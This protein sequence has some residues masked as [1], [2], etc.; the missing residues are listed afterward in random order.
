MY[1]VTMVNKMKEETDQYLELLKKILTGSIYDESSWAMIHSGTPGFAVPP[2][3]RPVIVPLRDALVKF[4]KR[5]NLLLVKQRPFSQHERNEGSGW[6]L[7][8]YTMVGH[9]RLDNVQF[10]VGEVLKNNIPG[11]FIETGVWRGGT[12]IFFRALLK[13]HNVADRNVWLAD[14]FEGL[15][16]PK[17]GDDGWDMSQNDYLKVSMEKVKSNFERFGLLD[18]QVKFIPGWF[19]ESLPKAPVQKLAI[20]RLDGDL[21]SSTMDALTNLYHKVSK[22]GFVIVDDYFSWPACQ[23]AMTEFIASNSIQCKIEKID[24]SA[25]YWK[26]I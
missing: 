1:T 19:S 4:L 17:S 6:P 13:A 3:L 14:S 20:L 21:Y 5:R 18:D 15:P 9:R 12:A 16:A 24:D 2:A 7:V 26:V 8:C 11:D 25:A 23:R 10:C 22:G